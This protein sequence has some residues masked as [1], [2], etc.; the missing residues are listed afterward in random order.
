M[1]TTGHHGMAWSSIFDPVSR[2]KILFVNS[3]AGSGPNMNSLLYV[4]YLNSL[5]TG[6]WTQPEPL[7]SPPD[8]VSPAVTYDPSRSRMLIFGGGFGFT[9]NDVWELRISESGAM[10]WFELETQGAPPPRNGASAIYDPVGDRMLMFGGYGDDAATNEI[11][12]LDLSD[13]NWT[14]LTPTGT[15]PSPRSNAGLVYDPDGARLLLIGGSANGV[16][17]GDTWELSLVG[18]PAWTERTSPGQPVGSGLNH[19][20]VDPSHERVLWFLPTGEIWAYELSGTPD[21]HPLDV[22]FRLGGTIHPTY[23][24]EF[25]R[26]LV[27]WRY[28]DINY[29]WALTWEPWSPLDPTSVSAGAGARLTLGVASPHPVRGDLIAGFSLASDSPAMLEVFD[30]TGRRLLRRDVSAMGA[31]AHR[32]NLTGGS[33]LPPGVYTMRLAQGARVA[34]ARAVVVR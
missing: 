25:D 2:C 18:A 8:R 23:D 3:S 12:S 29:T 27:E 30:V 31:G 16:E 9:L 14:L 15:P 28:R 20:V 22:S 1:P 6:S 10:G 7:P 5:G 4:L 19:V 34:R 13:L 21:W 33:R 24:P 17:L 11:W 26:V 32:L